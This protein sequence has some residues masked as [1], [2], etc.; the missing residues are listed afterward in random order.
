MDF[1]EP[2]VTAPQVTFSRIWHPCLDRKTSVPN[3]SS[4]ISHRIITGPNAGGKSTYIKNVAVLILLAQTLTVGNAH[5]VQLTPFSMLH[6][7]IHLVDQKG[8]ASL[9]EV[10]MNRCHDFIDKV[11]Q[12]QDSGYIFAIFDELFTS[13]NFYEGISGAYAICLEM[14]K[15]PNLLTLMTTHYSQLTELSARTGNKFQNFKVS[16]QKTDQGEIQFDYKIKRGISNQFI[17]LDLLKLKGFNSEIIA[18]ANQYLNEIK[19]LD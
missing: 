17:A 18:N 8:S 14:A 3:T 7:Y 9:F 12:L 16:V 13:T 2:T 19:P 4:I 5:Q 15:Y 10:E 1:L 6:S 11:S